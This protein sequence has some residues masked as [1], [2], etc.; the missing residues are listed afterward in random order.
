MRLIFKIF[1]ISFFG[2]QSINSQSIGIG[3]NIFPPSPEASALSE[4]AKIPV[5]EYTG[6]ANINLPLL[7]LKGKDI[8]IPISLSYHSAGNKVNEVSSAVGL[9]WTLNTGGVITRVVRSLPD[10]LPQGYVE[11]G[12]IL[13]NVS[14]LEDIT[15]G[16]LSGYALGIV[17]SEPDIYY[18]NIL[19]AS[20]RFTIDAQGEV[21]MTPEQDFKMLPPFGPRSVND[22]WTVIDKNGNAYKLGITE[23][24]REQSEI[25]NFANIEL[26]EEE[27]QYDVAWYLSEIETPTGENFT[28]EYKKGTDITYKN[29]IEEYN[30]FGP[31]LT[32]YMKIENE[33][34]VMNPLTP[35]KINSRFGYVT[36]TNVNDR[37]DLSG[38]NRITE[39]K[40]YNHRD[41]LIKTIILNQSYFNS[42]EN[43]I[44]QECKRLK[45]ESIDEEYEFEKSI[46]KYRFEYN[47]TELPK[48]NSP[49]IDHWGYYNGNGLTDFIPRNDPLNINAYRS[50]NENTTK[51]NILTEISY[52][53]GGF[54]KFN[55][56]LN[57]YRSG[58]SNMST[59]GL[60][61]SSIEDN[62]NNESPIITVY[63]YIKEGTNISSGIEYNKPI[64]TQNRTIVNTI[65]LPDGHTLP[66]F[67]SGENTRSSSLNELL[68][69]NGS[70]VGYEEVIKEYA[71]GSKEI[72]KYKNLNSNPDERLSDN[73]FEFA[74]Q[75][76]PLNTKEGSILSVLDPY[77]SPFA[78]PSQERAHQRGLLSERIVKD[79]NGNK[80]YQ[81]NNTYEE[82]T[83]A[84]IRYTIGYRIYVTYRFPGYVYDPFSGTSLISHNGYRLN[85]GKYTETNGSYQ[86][87]KS[88]E[89]TFDENQEN[90]IITNYKYSVLKPTMLKEQEVTLSNG[91]IARTTFTYPFESGIT[92]NNVL[93]Q[94]NQINNYIQ[95]RDYLNGEQLNF[96]EQIFGYNTSGYI[97]NGG[98][99]LPKQTNFKKKDLNTYTNLVI[100]RYDIHGN[101]L[102]YHGNDN[103]PISILWGYGN[104]YPVA[105]V[106]NAT[107]DQITNSVIGLNMASINE[108]NIGPKIS[109]SG[110]RNE[111]HK[112]RSHFTMSNAQVT[113]YT[114]N[115]IIGVTSIT[116][117]RNYTMYYEYDDF[118]RLQY[119][120]DDNRHLINENQYRYVRQN[121]GNGSSPNQLI[122]NV[123][124]G[125]SSNSHQEFIATASGGNGNFTYRWFR[126]IGTSS[127][128]FESS[129]SGS[130]PTFRLSVSCNT[131]KWMK[132]VT[133]SNGLTSTRIIQSNNRPCSG[134]G[135]DGNGGGT[136]NDDQENQQ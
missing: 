43:C 71:D 74:F 5:N 135:G 110:M 34:V 50:P 86:L 115:A 101:I 99:P 77:E 32:G 98:T 113:T 46:E 119:I 38:A 17:D 95:K 64:Y 132:L 39:L 94:K 1:L 67:L 36:L 28:Y 73:Y 14:S 63:K 78:P 127:S 48:R 49:E 7:E 21:I 41:D 61:I 106:V 108:T 136:G 104:R 15:N 97:N 111:I 25:I 76:K 131:R 35:Q 124:Y 130:L 96:E 120:R 19:G 116:D 54:T 105:R 55:Y 102:E 8:N 4:Y 59:G 31:D 121:N 9:G 118:N 88:E 112:I 92:I 107:Y 114:Y 70:N 2:I 11:S 57:T 37:E 27:R 68:D 82:K 44:D 93:D 126:G 66:Q 33:R 129:S 13:N 133:T 51:A 60:R 89:K 85:I 56:S 81:L 52:A 23:N 18:F 84:N 3:E 40:L 20:G 24:E 72:S 87:V 79:V 90:A 45:L 10:D 47:T 125:S 30:S 29:I 91:D 83:H 75:D 117:A 100:D 58:T 26:P 123:N 12:L 109:A 103:V 80:T 6:I 134:T 42:K 122:V 53:T 62:D 65:F 22:Y 69:L 16:S 128:D